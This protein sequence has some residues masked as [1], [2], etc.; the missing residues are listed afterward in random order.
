MAHESK[1]RNT[2][3]P[4]AFALDTFGDRWTLLIIR[5]MLWRGAKTYGEFMESPEGYATNILADRLKMLEA[6]DIVTRREDPAN[7]RRKIYRLT[8][9]GLELLPMLVEMLL[10]SARYDPNTAVTGQM[11]K[12][13]REDREGFMAQMRRRAMGK[14]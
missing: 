6:E 12:F 10:W 7:R 5:D 8:D 9:K 4:V 1:K 3:C 11:L 2:G 13:V 14:E